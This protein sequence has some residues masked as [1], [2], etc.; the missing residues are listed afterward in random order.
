[1]LPDRVNRYGQSLCDDNLRSVVVHEV[2]RRV[3][4][5]LGCAL[6]ALTACH[7]ESHVSP[8]KSSTCY[9][10][11]PCGAPA[12]GHFPTSPRSPTAAEPAPCALHGAD[13][14]GLCPP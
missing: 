1:M 6:G 4:Y 12:T 11:L 5:S 7:T 13:D 8:L 10:A 2:R 9:M 3:L 14:E